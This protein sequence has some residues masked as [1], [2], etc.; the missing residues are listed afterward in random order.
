MLQGRLQKHIKGHTD[1]NIKFCHYFNNNLN[2]IFEET[3]GCMFRHEIAPVCK[4]S[5]KCKFKK[6]QYSHAVDEEHSD[7]SN[8]EAEEVF[9]D[10][11]NTCGKCEYCNEIVDH[12]QHNL[13]ECSKCDFN[14]KCWA[15][16]N[17]HW[18]K[19]P[20]HIFSID[21]LREMGHKL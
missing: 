16:Y 11:E 7:E 6:C 1:Q 19:T 5:D 4:D 8:I 13:Q 21:E 9:S 14:S 12:T 15:E 17:I 10:E 18:Q 2:C 20:D 3:S